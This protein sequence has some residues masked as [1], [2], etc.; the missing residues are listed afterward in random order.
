MRRNLKDP[1]LRNTFNEEVYSSV[2]IQIAKMRQKHGL[3]QHKLARRLKTSQQVI[4]R[5]E[6]TDNSSCSL[7]TL[8][9][10]AQTFDKELKVQFA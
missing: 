10:L 8:I 6:S 3:S 5:L 4:S 9:K 7:A 2:A 1:G